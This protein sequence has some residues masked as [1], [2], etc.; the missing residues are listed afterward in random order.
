MGR[1][2]PADPR[3]PALACSGPPDGIRPYRLELQSRLRVEG[4]SLYAFLGERIARELFKTG[5]PVIHLA[6]GEHARAVLPH[7]RPGDVWHHL[8]TPHPPPGQTHHLGHHGAK[9][10]RGEMARFLRQKPPGA[11]HRSA[12]LR[13]GWLRL[14]PPPC[15]TKPVMFSGKCP[16]DRILQGI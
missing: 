13:V 14:S 5:E 2:A 12:G 15:R 3:R 9:M 1:G 7:R 6:S 16:F 8:R 4:Q 10:A 11:A